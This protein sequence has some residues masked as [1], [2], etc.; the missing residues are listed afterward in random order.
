MKDS[1]FTLIEVLIVA[2]IIGI[3]A[4]LAIPNYMLFK[5]QAVNAT[6]A[7]DARNIAPAAELVSAKGG[8]AEPLTISQS[9]PI[10][11]LP[12]AVLSPGTIAFIDVQANRYA[13]EVHGVSG[14]LEYS[15]DSENGFSV[16]GG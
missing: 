7:S 8:L 3:L 1:G 13:I 2:A 6:L 15:V 9:G 14:T 11:E 5:T 4:A 10:E 12:G 16:S